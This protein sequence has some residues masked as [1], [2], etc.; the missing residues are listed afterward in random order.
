MSIIKRTLQLLLLVK[1]PPRRTAFAFALGVFFGF[2]PLI[3]FHTLLGILFAHLLKLNKVPVLVG[4]YINNP[5]VA[6]PYFGFATWFGVWLTGVPEG[7]TI[8]HVGFREI[9][10]VDFW[11]EL[12]SQYALLYP[13]IVGSSVLAVVF[14][15]LA[16]PLCLHGIHKFTPHKVDQAP[17]RNDYGDR[18]ADPKDPR[19]HRDTND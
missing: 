3:G 16:Y 7:I 1:D 18:R 11:R 5:W 10:S 15:L 2:T 8:P 6:V 12:L 13:V 14:G 19:D 9:F 4:V 17:G